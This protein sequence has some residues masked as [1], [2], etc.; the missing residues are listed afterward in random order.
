M[1]C[2][3]VYV[4]ECTYD[5][6]YIR[7]GLY[8]LYTCMYKPANLHIIPKIHY[9]MYVQHI[10]MCMN[11]CYT[12]D[13]VYLYTHAQTYILLIIIIKTKTVNMYDQNY[14]QNTKLMYI[15]Y[16]CNTCQR[17]K[18]KVESQMSLLVDSELSMELLSFLRCPSSLSKQHSQ[19]RTGLLSS[20]DS[21]G[22]K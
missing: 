19:T 1:Y 6:L 4:H 9:Y 22:M 12:S 10:R 18:Y 20:S 17:R 5:I 2:T 3:Y 7:S 13:Q 21:T 11:V 15:K 16:K 14:T 8:I